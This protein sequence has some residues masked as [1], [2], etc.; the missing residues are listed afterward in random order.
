MLH[1]EIP[2]AVL[3]KEAKWTDKI[4]LSFFQ[5]MR[6]HQVSKIIDD[7]KFHLCSSMRMEVIQIYFFVCQ[8]NLF[9][10]VYFYFQNMD[11]FGFHL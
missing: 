10:S 1:S 5:M 9:H 3:L 4:R 6:T 8:Q 11:A 2:N 7:C